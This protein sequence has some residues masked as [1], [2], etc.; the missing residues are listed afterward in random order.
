M[1]RKLYSFFKQLRF[2]T[3]G[4]SMSSNL[5]PDG[6]NENLTAYTGVLVFRSNLGWKQSLKPITNIYHQNIYWRQYLLAMVAF[7]FL[8]KPGGEPVSDHLEECRR[9]PLFIIVGRSVKIKNLHNLLRAELDAHVAHCFDVLY[10]LACLKKLWC[11]YNGLQWFQN[12][13]K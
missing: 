6:L 3:S 4:T 11:F 2:R 10:S 7:N 1:C 12:L 13:K 9:K 8:M 5:I